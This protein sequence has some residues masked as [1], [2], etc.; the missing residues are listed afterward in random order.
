MSVPGFPSVTP[1]IL[2]QGERGGVVLTY[3]S[4][5]LCPCQSSYGKVRKGGGLNMSLPGFAFV[6]P[7]ILWQG[8][9]GGWF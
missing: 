1:L 3:V 8:E 4:T 6:T 5:W 9:K 7:F 2:W